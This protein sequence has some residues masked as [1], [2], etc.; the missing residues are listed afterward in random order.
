MHVQTNRRTHSDIGRE[1]TFT[2]WAREGQTVGILDTG[3]EYTDRFAGH[4]RAPRC[5]ISQTPERERA[6]ALVAKQGGQGPGPGYYPPDTSF[7]PKKRGP[8]PRVGV[9]HP[10]KNVSQADFTVPRNM[11]WDESV[12]EAQTMAGRLTG[13]A[14]QRKIGLA[15]ERTRIASHDGLL[16]GMSAT[17]SGN[18]PNQVGPG[19]YSSIDI[20]VFKKQGSAPSFS[21][22]KMV[23]GPEYLRIRKSCKATV[24]PGTY[25]LP[26]DFD[27]HP[28][29]KKAMGKTWD[30]KFPAPGHKVRPVESKAM[31]H[32]LSLPQ[33]TK[34]LPDF[35]R[36]F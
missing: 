18:I 7:L 21:V 5:K 31:T 2:H 19:Q 20:Q 28:E 25:D 22:G 17:A 12:G 15:G 11:S 34:V 13:N 4:T 29:V 8:L 10:R 26:S 24:P 3:R 1:Y 35:Q 27:I 33:R 23:E 30:S 32:L 9:G 16:K 6:H 14:S 36:T